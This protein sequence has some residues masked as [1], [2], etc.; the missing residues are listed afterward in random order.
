VELWDGT[1]RT[2]PVV[3][4]YDRDWSPGY[5]YPPSGLLLPADLFAQTV[6]P[7]TVTL[8][9]RIPVSRLS[10]VTSALGQALPQATVI[11]LVAYATRFIQTYKN[12]F[13]LAVSMAALA[14]LAGVLLV[15]NSVSL[16]M[17][18][19]R[20]EIGILKTL[21]FTRGHILAALGVE[22][23]L[24]ALIASAAGLLVVRGFLL[25]LG[26]GNPLAASVLRL[27][28]PLAAGI[29]VG[30]TALILATVF[31]VTGRPT[32]VSP[33]FVLNERVS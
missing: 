25:V 10:R 9:V 15:A 17:L 23:S 1:L 22:Y 12:L 19:R 21:G 26:L 24:I 7:E 28:V 13:V 5:L 4:S 2:Y 11:D 6:Q 20:Y 27:P 14:L 16:A 32:R 31:L 30:A 29:L 33:V 8:F 18:E 3:G